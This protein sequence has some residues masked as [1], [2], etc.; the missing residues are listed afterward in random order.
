VAIFRPNAFWQRNRRQKR[1]SVPTLWISIYA[2]YD[3]VTGESAG[4]GRSPV[5]HSPPDVA[6]GH[7]W[8]DRVRQGRH[9][10]RTTP[11]VGAA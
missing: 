4:R 7:Q 9:R 3:R 1:C 10:L 6:C 11:W 5:S 2:G 8:I